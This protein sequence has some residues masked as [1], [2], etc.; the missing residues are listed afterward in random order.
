MKVATIA[1]KWITRLNGLCISFS[2]MFE[3]FIPHEVTKNTI[4]C[5]CSCHLIWAKFIRWL[6]LSVNL[7]HQKEEPLKSQR[8]C[9]PFTC[10]NYWFFFSSVHES[11][12]HFC[13]R[14]TKFSRSNQSRSNPSPTY[15]LKSHEKKKI[16]FSKEIY[17]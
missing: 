7:W 5:L 13:V 6:I 11:W 2:T 10:V 3:I 12:H 14:C 17:E 16:L 4:Y 15:A 8:R 1:E 9:W